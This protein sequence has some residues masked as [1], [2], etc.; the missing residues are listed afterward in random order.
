M[1]CC[2]VCR[3]SSGRVQEKRTT[4]RM[5]AVAA[6]F[7]C[8]VGGQA[9]GTGARLGLK[10][11]ISFASFPINRR[12]T[13]LVIYQG[14]KNGVAR[15]S[16]AVAEAADPVDGGVGGEARTHDGHHCGAQSKEGEN[17]RLW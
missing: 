15:T 13:N 8:L 3:W 1:R 5:S 2:N 16:R 14:K 9:K 7:V 17:K 4:V 11:S 10:L 6:V 12:Q